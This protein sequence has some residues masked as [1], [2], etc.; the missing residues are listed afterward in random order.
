MGRHRHFNPGL[1]PRKVFRSPRCLPVMGLVIRRAPSTLADYR[2]GS[3]GVYLN[4]LYS[5]QS[6]RLLR[7]AT[8][9]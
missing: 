2:L 1:L 9:R 5:V 6:F 8:P 7:E 4:G 3:V